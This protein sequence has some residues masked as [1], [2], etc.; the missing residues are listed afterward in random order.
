M[1]RYMIVTKGYLH[2]WG[3]SFDLALSYYLTPNIRN[4]EWKKV[5]SWLAVNNRCSWVS[6]R[7][8]LAESLASSNRPFAITS[9]LGNGKENL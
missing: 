6:K 8:V 7:V 9:P 5:V 1:G 4:A 3:M 2:R